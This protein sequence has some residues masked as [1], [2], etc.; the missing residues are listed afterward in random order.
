MSMKALQSVKI[1]CLL[2]AAILPAAVNAQFTFTTN[3]DGSLN[4]YEYTGP[5]DIVSL[6]I[7]AMTNG[8]PVTTIGEPQAPPEEGIFGGLPSLQN[9]TFSTNLVSIGQNIFAGCNALTNFTLPDSITNIGQGTFEYCRSLTEVTLPKNLTTLGGFVFEYCTSLVH[10]TLDTNL[11][12]IEEQEFEYD[13]SLASI[14]IPDSVTNIDESNGGVFQGCYGLTN[15]VLGNGLTSIGSGLFAACANL[16]SITIGNSVTNIG[17]SAFAKCSDLTTLAIPNSVTSIGLQ[18]FYN[19]TSLTN[20]IIPDS[21]TNIGDEAFYDCTSLNGVYFQGNDPD[22]DN[23]SDAFQSDNRVTAYY[24]PGTTNW[25]S[26]FDDA[27]TVLWNPQAQT[28]GGS[29]GV[30]NNQFGF[31]ITGTT[32]I[33]IVVEASTNLSNGVWTPLQSCLVTNGSIYFSDPQWTNYPG[34]YYRIS[35]P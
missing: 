19:D 26:T 18:T 13:S 17:D 21:V 29:F 20:I 2:C 1:A 4:I 24:L 28:S 7:P 11:T 10:I 31:D 33:P 23:Y 12:I 34:R 5:Y 22:P 16:T 25:G 9:V 30:Q 14:C 8:L 27:P 6:V 32:N 15:V 35:S 3:T